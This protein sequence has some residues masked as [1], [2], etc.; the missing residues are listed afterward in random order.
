[1]SDLQDL[2]SQALNYQAKGQLPEAM[3]LFNQL[4]IEKPDFVAAW[5][6]RAAILQ[7]LGHPFD[8]IMNYDCAISLKP[9]DGIFYNNRGAAYLDMKLFGRAIEDFDRASFR[10][11]KLAESK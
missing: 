10:N 5:N 7:K 4:L 1:M 11:P 8:A 3:Q 6:N 9:D 2:F